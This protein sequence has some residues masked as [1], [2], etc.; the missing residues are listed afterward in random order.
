MRPA[1]GVKWTVVYIVW[2]LE[3]SFGPNVDIQELF[4]FRWYLVFRIC[5]V[6]QGKGVKEIRAQE[7]VLRNLQTIWDC[8]EE[9]MLAE[10]ARK[11]EET[12]EHV[13]PW[14]WQSV[15]R[16]EK[17]VISAMC[18]WEVSYSEDRHIHWFWQQG[19]YCRVWPVMWGR[20][21]EEVEKV[22]LKS[23]WLFSFPF[24]CTC[25]PPD[26]VGWVFRPF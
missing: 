26:W 10:M 21:G 8:S 20:G 17:V 19:G 16:R 25:S 4:V 24:C 2:N 18:H 11:A 14:S 5:T 6:T 9:E 23:G 7:R 1:G 22:Y 12:Q 15:L 3:Q 13:M